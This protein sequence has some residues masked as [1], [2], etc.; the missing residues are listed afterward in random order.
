MYI[1]VYIWDHCQLVGSE[2]K[3]MER[4][5]FWC[6]SPGNEQERRKAPSA[7]DV[8]ILGWWLVQSVLPFDESTTTTEH[9]T[10]SNMTEYDLPSCIK[11]MFDS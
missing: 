7:Q 4:E 5:C 8:Q 3:E 1:Y 11:K 2:S 10:E 6:L 9:Y